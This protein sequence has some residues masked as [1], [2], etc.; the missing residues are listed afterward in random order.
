MYGGMASGVYSKSLVNTFLQLASKGYNIE[1]A[2]IYNES[3]ITRARNALTHLFL[4]SDAEYLLF[5]D[6]DQSFRP[7]DVV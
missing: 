4:K 2:D 5:I 1:Y 6:A 7:E 3:L